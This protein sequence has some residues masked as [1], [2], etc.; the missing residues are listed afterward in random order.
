MNN[1]H[2]VKS[3]QDNNTQ[4]NIKPCNYAVKLRCKIAQLN[5]KN[6]PHTNVSSYY[7]WANMLGH[8]PK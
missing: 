1:I 4:S 6:N 3:Q 8:Q 5:I 2:A 7:N